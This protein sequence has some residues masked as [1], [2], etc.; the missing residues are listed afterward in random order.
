MDRVKVTHMHES[1][2]MISE[3]FRIKEKDFNKSYDGFLQIL[4]TITQHDNHRAA[5]HIPVKLWD[6]YNLSDISKGY[7]V[8]IWLRDRTGNYLVSSEWG[9]LYSIKS[10]SSGR[11]T[12]DLSLI[13]TDIVGKVVEVTIRYQ[14]AT[15]PNGSACSYKVE[16]LSMTRKID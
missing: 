13:P 4:S 2:H 5:I 11:L 12:I 6:F 1:G 14:K 15:F 3:T 8:K 9:N 16:A 10:K 7:R